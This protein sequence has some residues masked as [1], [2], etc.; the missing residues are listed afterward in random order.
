MPSGALKLEVARL[1]ARHHVHDAAHIIGDA[2][3][4]IPAG[5]KGQYVD[6]IR[7]L[8]AIGENRPARILP[9]LLTRGKGATMNPRFSSRRFQCASAVFLIG[10][11]RDQDDVELF[12]EFCRQAF[13][14]LEECAGAETRS[15][16]NAMMNP[17]GLFSLTQTKRAPH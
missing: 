9:S 12:Q 3:P 5:K 6:I 10:A 16:D 4:D 15:R 7:A 14:L 11:D 2:A 13:P 8:E 17:F 1:R